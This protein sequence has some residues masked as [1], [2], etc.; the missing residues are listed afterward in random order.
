M[1][2]P[3]ST[4]VALLKLTLVTIHELM[5]AEIVDRE[6]VKTLIEESFEKLHT[7]SDAVSETLEGHDKLVSA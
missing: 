3:R 7:C 1:N 4:K 5:G 6:R 2:E